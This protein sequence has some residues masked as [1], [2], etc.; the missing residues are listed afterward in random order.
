MIKSMTGFSR[1][2]C[3]TP[4]RK[5]TVEVR[6]L[7]SKQLDLST[8]IPNIYRERETQIRTLAA[9]TIE[10]GKSDITISYQN[11]G[12]PTQGTVNQT[13]FVNYYNELEELLRKVGRDANQEHLLG[14][15]LRM[16]DVIGTQTTEVNDTELDMLMKTVDE[17]LTNFDNFRRSE[18]KVL[19][20]DLLE[21]IETIRNLGAQ[22]PQYETQR[23]DA[24]KA[25][26]YENLEKLKIEVDRNRLE[27][28]LIY[29]LEKFDITEEKVRLTRHLDYF[30][31]I[32]ATPAAGRKLGFI[33]Q[34]IGREIN[35][36]GSKANQADLQKIVVTMKDEL[37][38][39]KE[40]LLN[41]L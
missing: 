9:K 27:Q 34:E 1:A 38:K 39:I 41:I 22:I 15:I 11:I 32:A 28:E 21:R 7:N 3:T 10:R 24:V 18:G 29:Y 2:E 6:S 40:Q 4:E 36:T 20:N 13:L 33:A 26:L 5:I 23:I 17:A 14:A 30:E 35:T 25:R 31:E 19:M 12:T 37:E 16:P 8:R